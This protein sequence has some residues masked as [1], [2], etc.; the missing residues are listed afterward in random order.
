MEH[1]KHGRMPVYDTSAVKQHEAWG[2]TAV[3]EVAAEPAP[4]PV[5][6]VPESEEDERYRLISLAET[7]GVHI[8]RRWGLERLRAALGE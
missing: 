6:S 5:A 3:E 2:W 7:R 1:P 8:D 4:E